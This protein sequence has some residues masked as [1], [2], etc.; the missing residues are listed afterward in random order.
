MKT[1][2]TTLL[3]LLIL[4]ACE[5]TENT[6]PEVKFDPPATEIV[7]FSDTLHNQIISDPYRWLEDKTDPKVRSWSENQSEYTHQ[8]IETMG[9]EIEGLKDELYSIYDREQRSAPFYKGSREFISIKKKGDKHST[10]FRIK[11]SDTIKIFSPTDID[12]SGQ[13]SW[14]STAYNKDGSIVAVATQFKG[15]EIATYRFF[16]TETMEE[17]YAPL[18]NLRDLTFSNDGSHAYVTLR[19]QEMIDNQEPLPTYLHKLGSDNNQDKF[20]IAAPSA[21]D[22]AQVYD[23]ENANYTYTTFGDFYSNTLHIKKTGT[24]GLGKKVYSSKKFNAFP[25]Y[26]DG[27]FFFLTNDSAANFKIMRTDV[28]KP[29]FE[30]WTPFIDVSMDIVIKD[31][32]WV[33]DKAFVLYKKDVLSRLSVYDKQGEKIE[34]L[35]LPE[36]GDIGSISYNEHLNT[37]FVSVK[38]YTYPTKLY[39]L[40]PESFE[41]ELFYQE[42]TPIPTD[43]IV[44]KMHKFES[45]DGTEVP[46]FL[47]Y[48]KDM[49]REGDNPTLL[50]GYGGFNISLTPSFLGDIA[51]FI[52][53]GGI[54]AVANLRG[55]SEYGEDWHRAGMLENKQNVF[56]DFQAAAQYLIDEGYTNPNRL[57]ISGRSNGGLLTGATLTQAPDMFKAVVIGVPLLDMIRY[58][59]FLIAQYWIPEYGS[60]DN[61]EDFQWLIEYSPYHNIDTNINYPNTYIHTGEY[62][63]RVDPLHAKKMAAMLQNG[64]N[65]TNPILLDVD[66]EGGHGSG[67]SGK[68]VEKL[69]STRY[70][71]LK[72]IMNSLGMK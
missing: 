13:T 39:K 58:H 22:Y 24:Q 60:A 36:I 65:Q 40:N 34:D 7:E 31:F 11:D 17:I 67:G 71:E 61:E 23:D 51:T 4:V 16:D 62:D 49:V 54:Y 44:T 25:K 55:G 47:T 53:R 52:N 59:K 28:N 50:Y 57:A 12:S 2:L 10:L 14:F 30:N 32:V 64:S 19:S 70:R 68:S 56:D 41:F 9:D 37:I 8:F 26:H 15:N 66:F 69:V 46:I 29:E 43:R 5:N 20:I 72:F 45:K 1:L 3:L 33:G 27:E 6:M 42:P 18:E 63:T 21:K 35:E 38:S 48:D